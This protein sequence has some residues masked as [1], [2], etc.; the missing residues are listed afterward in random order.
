MVTIVASHNVVPNEPTPNG[1]LW[2]S[3]SDQTVR[4]GH[5]PTIYIYKAKHNQD[6]IER[7]RNSLGK[8]LVHY[9]PMAGRLRLAESGRMEVDCNAKGVTLLEAESTKTLDDYGDFVPSDSIKELLPKVDH[10]PP[11]EEI[12]LFIV[13]LTRFHGDEGLAIALA[14]SHPLADGVAAIQFINSWAKVA[15][16][17]TLEPHELPFLDR[18]IFK[19]QH[20]PPRFHHPELNS[21]PLKLGSSD[22]ILEEKKK[23][24]TKKANDGSVKEGS[25]PY[26]RYEAI[27]AHIWRS[28][29]K[30][31]QLDENQPTVVRFNG[32]I[33]SRLVP[34][35]P[36]NYF[37]NALAATVTP[38]CY[39]GDIILNPLS[40]AAQKIRESIELLTN[41][42]IRSQLSV[43]LGQEQLD[44]VKGFF[45]G[46]GEPRNA[47]FAGNPNLHITSW[48]SMPMYEADFGWG[49]P[50]YVGLAY[51]CSQ[52]RALILPSPDGDRSVIL[53]MDFQIAHIQLFKKFFYEDI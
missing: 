53:S 21:L 6:T 18:T 25:S 11:I 10:I 22:S 9:Y 27:A 30:A 13:Q 42:Y 19:F 1:P 29:S 41:D 31:R 17:D 14:F 47:P 24:M 20:S 34:P 7:M 40:Y 5:T 48:M 46:E 8:I 52:D 3:D 28:A 36:W 51:V 33:R 32:N 45:K 49:K 43:K 37:G 2:L 26:S 12:P 23:I 4:L 39:V 15:R 35:L 50:I 38:K 16:G 44:F